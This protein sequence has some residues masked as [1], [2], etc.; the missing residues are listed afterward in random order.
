MDA[1]YKAEGLT[2]ES[3]RKYCRLESRL[4]LLS[5]VIGSWKNPTSSY[6]MLGLSYFEIS[7]PSWTDVG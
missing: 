1:R 3:V 4:S 7:N 6:Q 2:G 5:I